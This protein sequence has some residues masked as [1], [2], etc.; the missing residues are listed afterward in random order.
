MENYKN[1]NFSAEQ[2]NQKLAWVGDKS[3][4][5]T[6]LQETPV[7]QFMFT[8]DQKT[9]KTIIDANNQIIT[10]E[11]NDMITEPGSKLESW[12]VYVDHLLCIN[13]IACEGT[14]CS[15]NYVE[16]GNGSKKDIN[17]NGLY[18]LYTDCSKGLE[19]DIG[20]VWQYLPLTGVIKAGSTFVIRGRQTNTIKGSMIKVDSYDMEWDIE[21]KQNKAAFYLCAGDS[22]KPLLE[23][24]SLGNPWE[25]NLIG[26]IDSCGFGA[27]A[28]AEGNSPLLVNDNWNDI[29]FVRWFMFE[30]AKQGTKAFAKRKTKDLWTYIDLTK[31]TTK[32]GNS[33]QYYYSDNIKLKYTPKA[34]Y[35]GKDFFTI[36]TLFRQDIPNYVNLTFGRQ[37]TDSGSGATRCFN[38]IS[39][40]YYDEYVEIRKQGEEWSKHYSIIEKDSSNTAN[41]NK[42][43]NYYKRYK[44]IAPDG[45][46]VTT[47]KCI[48]DKLTAGTYEYRIRRDNSNYSSKIYIFKVLGDSEVTT[49]S[50]I[51]TSDQQGFNWQEYQ[52]WKKS[53]Y[54]IS[55]EQ[56]IEFTI[57]TGEI[58]TDMSR[59]PVIQ[60]LRQDQVQVNNFARYE[61]VEN[62]TAPT[63]VTCQATG[64]KL[65][66][67]KEQPSGDAYR[68]PWL[69][70]YFP[71]ATSSS[72]PKENT[73]QHKPMYIKY[74]VSD[75]NIK[76]TAVQ[77]NGIWEVDS[78]STKYDF[79]NQIENLTIDKMTLST[80]T[81]EDLAIYSPD[82]QNFYT[83]K[84]Q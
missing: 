74:D 81:E 68:I 80:S 67:N 45:T 61:V 7:N 46:F 10:V 76:I 60:V 20:Y 63:Y 59:K 6:T 21:F 77:I 35:L 70:A 26:Y 72:N 27:E 5:A 36:S 52:A 17:L 48:I 56:N 84:L 73:A 58:T 65:I 32:A 30:T 2:I 39:V 14:M 8:K 13:S 41:I 66:S 1:L 44:W 18:L 53:S 43:I 69:L 54:M 34:S 3:K 82:N 71:A 47:H 4:L 31:N 19:S 49:F 28:P 79:N 23:S 25:A 57:N 42:F 11:T 62:I 24:N 50:Y 75:T 83:L 22:F 51:Q 40:G 16:L 9:L 29:I 55:K 12:N 64:Y 78:S 37:A 38:W 15:H 33:I